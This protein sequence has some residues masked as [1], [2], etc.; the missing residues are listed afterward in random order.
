MEF[1]SKSITLKY[2]DVL[3]AEHSRLSACIY[4]VVEGLLCST[5]ANF[6]MNWLFFLV[7]CWKS[8]LSCVTHTKFAEFVGLVNFVI[9][10]RDASDTYRHKIAS[11][12]RFII[13]I[14]ININIISTSSSSTSLSAYPKSLVHADCRM[15]CSYSLIFIITEFFGWSEAKSRA[16][17]KNNNDYFHPLYYNSN[18]INIIRQH[19]HTH[20]LNALI[21]IVMMK[22]Q[23]MKIPSRHIIWTSEFEDTERENV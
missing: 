3:D 15:L 8:S 17:I 2:R 13:N 11:I 5:V 10:I 4:V 20:S 12:F 21:R 9:L 18:G 19:T 23:T 22:Q 1:P 6:T 14:S 7:G 16:I